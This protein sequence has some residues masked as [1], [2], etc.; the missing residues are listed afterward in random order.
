MIIYLRSLPKGSKNTIAVKLFFGLR[1]DGIKS[2]NHFVDK[3]IAFSVTFLG[4]FETRTSIQFLQ[5]SVRLQFH[6]LGRQCILAGK[7]EDLGRNCLILEITWEKIPD[8]GRNLEENAWIL[9]VTRKKLPESWKKYRK[10]FR[11]FQ[12]KDFLQLLKNKYN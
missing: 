7:L 12:L 5:E 8:L 2:A 6:D 4:K 3:G 10:M 11:V 9:E 1:F